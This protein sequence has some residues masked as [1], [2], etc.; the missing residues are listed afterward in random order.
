VS[1]VLLAEMPDVLLSTFEVLKD[2]WTKINCQKTK[3]QATSAHL[4]P[5]AD[6]AGNPVDI[7][8]SFVHDGIQG[9]YSLS[10]V[11][12]TPRLM[13]YDILRTDDTTYSRR[14]S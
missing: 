3:I 14:V 11:A 5:T 13:S 12:R 6:V 1:V 10:S 7:A 8:D 2:S 9:G 4:E